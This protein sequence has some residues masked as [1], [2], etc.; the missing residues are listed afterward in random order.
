MSRKKRQ[1]FLEAYD[2]YHD[3]IYRHCFFRVFNKQRAEEVA[4]EAFMKAYRYMRTNVVHNLRALLY[5]IANNLIIDESR[6]K[7]EESLDKLMEAYEGFGPSR[8]GRE[9]SERALMLKQIYM[10]FSKL[11]EEERALLR[12]RYIDDLDP[13]DIAPILRIS[14]NNVSVKLNRT[15]NKLR[16]VMGKEAE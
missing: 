9:D 16:E 11:N 2:K 8:D 1:Q 13:K 5:R 4:Q 6:K 12:M 10:N 14:A 15:V 7:K 3:A